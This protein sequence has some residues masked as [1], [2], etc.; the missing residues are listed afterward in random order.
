MYVGRYIYKLLI[1]KNVKCFVNLKQELIYLLEDE[2]KIERKENIIEIYMCF[3]YL[4]VEGRGVVW[5][6][7]FI[8]I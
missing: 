2:D 8:V 4:S 5:I 1:K 7:G 6:K 3:Y